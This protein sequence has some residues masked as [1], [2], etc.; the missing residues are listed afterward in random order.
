MIEAHMGLG[1]PLPTPYSFMCPC[2]RWNTKTLEFEVLFWR[3]ELLGL[4]CLCKPLSSFLLYQK[5]TW[6]VSLHLKQNPRIRGFFEGL[7][8]RAE[9]LGL[10]Y[11]YKTFLQT[12]IHKKKERMDLLGGVY[13]MFVFRVIGQTNYGCL[14]VVFGC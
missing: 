8:W 13:F 1:A 11:F 4:M 7:F 2:S 14:L 5:T 12:L 6:R 3:A 10:I 9:L